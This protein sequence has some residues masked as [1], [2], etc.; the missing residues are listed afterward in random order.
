MAKDPETGPHLQISVSTG[1]L[2]I[3][4]THIGT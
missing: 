2:S 4:N 3:T 1:A